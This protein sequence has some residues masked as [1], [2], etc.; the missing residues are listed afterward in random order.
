MNEPQQDFLDY[1]MILQVHP[2]AEPEIIKSAYRRLAQMYHPDVCKDPESQKKMQLINEAYAVISDAARRRA[3]HRVWLMNQ[4]KSNPKTGAEPPESESRQVLDEYFRCLL[5]ENWAMAYRKLSAKDRSLIPLTDFCEWKEAVKALYQMGAYVIKF[6]RSYEHCV[7]DDDEYE[8]V[9]AYSVIVTD[10]DNRTGRVSEEAYTKYVVWE[11]NTWRVRLG[12]Q[13]LR[14][15]IY[16]LRYLATQAPEIDANRLYTDALLKQ[17]RLTGFLSRYGLL[18]RIDQEIARAKR[19]RNV[20]TLTVLTIRPLGSQPGVNV[21][22][23]QSMCLA[24]AAAQLKKTVR[25]VDIA[26]RFSEQRLAVL[27]VQTGAQAANR[28]LVR[29]LLQIKPSEGLAYRVSGSITAY[30]GESAEDLM[31]RAEHDA[32]TQVV[33]GKNNVRKYHFSLDDQQV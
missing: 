33:V 13:Q 9:D 15:I 8:R 3:Y 24:D 23:Y 19:F 2:S 30:Q 6:F 28:A 32:R 4:R 21:S 10:R 5:Q 18:E 7:V 25:T 14:P 1:Y 17:D 20:F 11:Q 12:Y 16:K 29:F 26:A 27:M 22:D 31:L